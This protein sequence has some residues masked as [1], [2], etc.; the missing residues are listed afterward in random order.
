MSVLTKEEYLSLRV[1]ELEEKLRRQENLLKL[2]EEAYEAAFKYIDK[3]IYTQ[4]C[5]MQHQDNTELERGQI[6]GLLKA[7]SI[8]E[9][10]FSC[11][12]RGKTNELS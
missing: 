1:E 11:V 12:N 10:A 6:R 2:Q 3:A 9:Y 5:T 7:G 8:V 4:R